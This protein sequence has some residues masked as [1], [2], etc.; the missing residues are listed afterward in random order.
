MR[1][2]G[3]PGL[4]RHAM[5]SGARYRAARFAV[6]GWAGMDGCDLARL[7]LGWKGLAG[8]AWSGDVW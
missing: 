2:H 4:A 7:R 5:G 1:R 8:E 3:Q 6:H